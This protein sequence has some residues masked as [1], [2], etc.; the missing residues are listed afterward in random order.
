VPDRRLRLGVIGALIGMLLLAGCGA[1]GGGGAISAVST[2]DNHGFHGTYLGD[3]PYQLPPAPLT[4]TAGRPTALTKS[5]VPV[6][7]IFF[8]YSHCPDIC[9]VVMST[10]ASALIRLDAAQRADVQVVFVTT[11]PARD[12]PPVL[13]E[14]LDRFNSSFVGLTGSLSAIDAFGKPLHVYLEKG[15]KLASGGYEV[16]HSTY[17]YGVV[18]TGV[19]VIWDQATSPAQMRADIIKLLKQ[20]EKA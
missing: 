4:D 10:I 8:G 1:S 9:Q 20:K 19:Q 11:D 17:I 16:D 2:P 18:G 14:Y 7:V 5:V 13:R 12:T 15:T 3:D 6:K